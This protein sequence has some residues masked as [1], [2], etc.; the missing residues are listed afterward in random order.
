MAGIVGIG[1][2]VADTL[3]TL[4]NYPQE[5]TKLR[6]TDSRRAGGGPVA[7]GLVAASK[8]G[9]KTTYLGVLSDDDAGRFLK[10]DF[11]KYGVS[12]DLITLESCGRSFTSVIW[13]SEES[14]SRTCVFER[15]TLPPLTYLLLYYH[16]FPYTF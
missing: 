2:C 3:Y 5:D 8:L 16:M 4:P 12:T 15:G 13:L 9:A 11:E 6:A 14:A 10:A 7:T 1:A